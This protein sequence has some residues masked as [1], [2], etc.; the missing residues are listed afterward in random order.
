MKMAYKIK[1]WFSVKARSHKLA[2]IKVKQQHKGFRLEPVIKECDCTDGR[3]EHY[4]FKTIKTID[5][6][7]YCKGIF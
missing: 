5:R 7:N 6:C 1:G 2:V 4:G 3:V